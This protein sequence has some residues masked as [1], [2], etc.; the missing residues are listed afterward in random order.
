LLFTDSDI[1]T[2]A[3]LAVVDQEVT[4][5]A[6]ALNVTL[7]G[8]GS[9]IRRAVEEAGTEI[10]A[11]FQNFSGYLVGLGISANHVAAV[12]NTLTTAINRPRARLNQVCALDPDPTHLHMK[13]W[14]EYR[15][16]TGFYRSLYHRKVEDRFEKKMNNYRAEASFAWNNLIS[17]GLP[18]VLQPL[19]CPGALRELGSGTWGASNVSAGGTG[20]TE[21]GHVYDIAITWVN[22]QGYVTWSNNGNGESAPSAIVTLPAVTGS[23]LTLTLTGLNPPDGTIP[24]NLG[25]ADGIYTPQP[26]SG[27][28]V[29]VG[30]TGQTLWLQNATPIPIATTSYTLADAPTLTGNPMG[31]GQHP[32]YNFAFQNVLWRA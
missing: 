25:T 6:T 27:W 17:S 26:A 4:S 15:A 14:L 24:Q 18:I 8:P 31:Q 20:S 1:I 2:P 19:A 5:D 23:V 7:S 9:I 16:L 10:T 12:L 22:S 32:D 11:A 30:I 21:I 13:R 29:Y 3:D 28:N